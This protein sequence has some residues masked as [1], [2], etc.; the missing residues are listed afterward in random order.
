MRP[1]PGLAHGE[2]QNSAGNRHIEIRWDYVKVIRVDL[3]SL[4]RLMY[5]HLGRP[6][7]QIDHSAFM[8]G[9]EMRNKDESQPRVAWH[10]AQKISERFETP[11]GASDGCYRK[12]RRK[13]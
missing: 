8:S 9:V 3:D 7:E 12:G 4:L 13:F 5:R 11:G 10:G 6:C 2:P 1:S